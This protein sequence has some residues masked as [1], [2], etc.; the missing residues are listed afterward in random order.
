MKITRLC[1]KKLMKTNERHSM[2][3]GWKNIVKM[4]TLPKANYRFN[5]ISIKTIEAFFTEIEETNLKL[6][7]NHRR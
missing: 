7:W 6:V 2:C 3:M 4:A 5:S 1:V